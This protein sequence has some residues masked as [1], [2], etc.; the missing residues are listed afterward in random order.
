MNANGATLKTQKRGAQATPR[1]APSPA[2]R[3]RA[4]VHD[5]L[6]LSLAPGAETPTWPNHA[7]LNS[8]ASRSWIISDGGRPNTIDGR[9]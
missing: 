4:P 7:C 3:A 8:F 5:L 9:K 6:V 1:K 2:P